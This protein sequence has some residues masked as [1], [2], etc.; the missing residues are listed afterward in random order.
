MVST[1]YRHILHVCFLSIYI[2]I[3]GLSVA[4]PVFPLASSPP[5]IS[6]D[7]I[8][9]Y[10]LP[11]TIFIYFIRL[12]SLSSLPIVACN[13]AGLIFYDI[14]PARPTL[15]RSPLLGPKI[16]I[17]VVTRGNFPD[18]V[19]K[20]VERNL[21]TCYEVGLDNFHIEIVTDKPINLEGLPSNTIREI[22]VPTDYR[23]KT[24]A[25]FKARALQ[26]A[27]E[28][29]TDGLFSDDY[30]VHL[31]EETIMTK[32]S[33]RGILNFVGSNEYDIGQGLITYANEKIVNI[34]TTLADSVR[35]G[36][37]LGC[38]RFCLKKFSRPLF[39]IKGSFL[40]CRAACELE[41]TFDHGLAGSITEDIYF[42]MLATSVGKKFGWIEGW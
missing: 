1:S 23:T 2:L 19:R 42:A 25:L 39:S 5:D 27:L 26:Y 9:L 11:L 7:P 24:G 30:I 10:G 29:N 12:L 34:W 18:L 17:R 31:D 13:M 28:S 8:E 4:G 22:V 32:D 14:Y 33:I 41:L 38:L 21:N 35:V 15:K 16:I 3:F 20:N 40:V 36:L 6:D 37:D